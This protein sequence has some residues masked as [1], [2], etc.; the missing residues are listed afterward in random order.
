MPKPVHVH[1]PCTPIRDSLAHLGIVTEE[2]FGE[3]VHRLHRGH[4]ITEIGQL[5]DLDGILHVIPKRSLSELQHAQLV[6]AAESA[7]LTPR[8][9]A[10]GW[11]H[12]AGRWTTWI[13]TPADTI[14]ASA[15]AAATSADFDPAT[16]M[17]A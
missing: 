3:L 13:T 4:L 16:S 5:V 14:S 2:P 11:E 7:W 12:D 9:T 17:T 1:F 8:S 10:N 6:G 15:L